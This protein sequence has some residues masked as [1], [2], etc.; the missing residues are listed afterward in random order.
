MKKF[1]FVVKMA[2]VASLAVGL[3]AV[4]GCGETY[5]P[6]AFHVFYINED[7]SELVAMEYDLEATELESQVEELISVMSED[8]GKVD[9]VKPIQNDLKISKYEITD[10]YLSLY[11]NAAYNEMDNVTEVLCRSAVVKTLCQLEG[12][13]GVWFYVGGVQISD[14]RGNS[15][16][17][18]NN[19]SFIDNPGEDIQNYQ[20]TELTL[21]YASADGKGLVKEVHEKY[22]SSNV[23]VEKLIIEEL[24]VN[25]DSENAQ[26]AIPAGTKLIN[27][28]VLDGICVV[29]FDDN[30]LTQN[31]AISEEVV[32]YSIVNS[33]TE[34]STIKTVQI[35]VNGETNRVYRED[36][37]LSEQYQRNLDLVV[38]ESKT[39]VVVD[40]TQ[41][42]G[43][44]LNNIT[45]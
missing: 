44:V 2:L 42:K 26:C 39:V 5:D 20:E 17:L 12:I 1:L 10:G 38:D 43:G 28:S 40:D 34:L 7:A 6:K 8:T 31:F 21:Y 19:D 13:N 45:E 33:L 4:S 14:A 30:F 22:S 29:N 15:I 41:E 18:M 16:G 27:I 24:L 25:P 36:F 9:Y 35:S 23:S 37:S 32:I 11:F 3:L